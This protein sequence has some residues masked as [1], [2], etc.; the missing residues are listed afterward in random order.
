MGLR[1]TA[2][3]RLGGISPSAH[4]ELI[5][6]EAG[7]RTMAD[8]FRE[9]LATLEMA[10]EDV[11]W[12]RMGREQERE[13]TRGGLDAII[14]ISK[15]MFLSNP[16]INRAANVSAFYTW[17]QGASFI[18]ADK[19]VKKEVMEPM[20]SDVGNKAELYG[21][22][23]QVLTDLD[24]IVEGNLFFACFTDIRGNV[25][26]R[27]FPTRQ[28]REI[29]HIEGD[30]RRVAFY[31]R[32]WSEVVFDME[33]GGSKVIQSE[34]LYPDIKFRPKKRPPKINNVPV[35]WDAP[36][37]HHREGGLKSMMFGVPS[38]YAAL[39]W[40]RAYKKFLENWHT[41]VASLSKFAW[42]VTTKGSKV[43]G[44]AA[45][46]RSTIDSTDEPLDQ[47]DFT[48]GGAF[49][50]KAGDD[51]SPIPKTGAQTSAEDARMSRLMVASAMNIPDTILSGDVDVGNFATSKT[52]DRPTELYMINRQ[53][54]WADLHKDIFIYGCEAKVR[55][56]GRNKIKGKETWKTVGDMKLSV[57]EF[58]SDPE[59]KVSFPPILEDDPADVVKSIV[60]A[61]TLEGRTSA[62]TLPKELISKLLMESLGVEDI[63]AALKE[64]TSEEETELQKIAGELEALRAEAAKLPKADPDNPEPD[65][66]PKEGDQE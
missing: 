2:V 45:K 28:I 29:H 60:T 65:K 14:E 39:D 9:N 15:A 30:I 35:H 26:V 20:M 24:L 52:L 54:G 59:V 61:A 58:D 49:V 10:N 16:L 11:G 43:K 36:I 55:G 27:S 48:A 5:T 17:A 66:P 4:A 34:A 3:E 64:L 38:T 41:L 51:I 63:T 62:S 7:A 56:T 8:I 37:Y 33:K 13:F 1:D 53:F 31:R 57:I 40:A 19:N 42:K 12:R 44:G 22:Q 21:H 18:A 32:V 6:A 47:H 23:A 25:Q 46:L 50:G